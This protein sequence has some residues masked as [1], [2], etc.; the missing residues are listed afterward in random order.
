MSEQMFY[1]EEENTETTED[2][3]E[4]IYAPIREHYE[5]GLALTDEEVDVVADAAVDILK[6]ILALFGETNSSIDEYEGDDGE[7]ILDVN[8]G[9]LAVLI[10]RHGRTIDA[11]Q[12][13]FSSLVS[14]RLQFH[15]PVVVD[16]EGYKSRR[17][18]KLQNI[19][20]SS[21]EKALR[22]GGRVTLQPMNAF[23]RRIVHLALVGNPNVT[24]HSEG[25]EPNRKIV[26]TP[27]RN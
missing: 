22:I 24:T 1:T 16:I 17:R 11:L 21:A 12:Q 13:V 4:D 18:Q 23:E 19:A 5:A 25:E 2:M 6:S 3:V 9:D 14:S 26:I 15:Y 10:G 8:G 20:L 27:V 7:L